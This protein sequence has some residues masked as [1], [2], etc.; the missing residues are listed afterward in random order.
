MVFTLV[1]SAM[2]S[3][4][5]GS[6]VEDTCQTLKS[7]YVTNRSPRQENGACRYSVDEP[8]ESHLILFFSF[9]LI[10]AVA[11]LQQRS[12]MAV[13]DREPPVQKR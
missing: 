11:A 1:S 9:Y 7:L 6:S 13:T 2:K 8:V 5:Y 12:P 4:Q 10:H 3:I